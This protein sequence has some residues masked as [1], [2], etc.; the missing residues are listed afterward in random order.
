MQFYGAPATKD[1]AFAAY[2]PRASDKIVK[3]LMERMLPCIIDGRKI[4]LD[5]K[6]SA[7][8]RASNPVS[9][10]KWEWEKT[11]SI[12]CALINKQ[13]GFK[14]ALDESNDD[15]DYLFGRLLAVAD[16]LERRALG[17]DE[18]RASNAIRYMNAFSRHPER[19]WNTIQSCLQPYQAKLGKKAS[20]LNKIIDE[21]GSRMPVEKFNNK[22][23]SGLYLLGFYSQ[24]HELYRKKD[25]N[26]IE[27]SIQ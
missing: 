12:T 18:L 24:R 5:I 27:E 3:G 21:V 11:L 2:G 6:D 19:T 17:A 9:M 22:P 7:I 25:T 13:E 14:V 15:R 23:L 20:D 10:E 16:V 1:I 8:Q 4:P 26:E